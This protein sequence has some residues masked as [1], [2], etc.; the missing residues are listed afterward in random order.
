VKSIFIF[1]SDWRWLIM[2]HSSNFRAPT[3]S[4]SHFIFNIFNSKYLFPAVLCIWFLYFTFATSSQ[5]ISLRGSKQDSKFT[6]DIISTARRKELNQPE[7]LVVVA[8]HAVMRMNKLSI[9]D[10]SDTGWYLLAY[11]KDQGFPGTISSHIRKGIELIKTDDSSVL[12]F[13]GGQTRRDVGPTSEAASYY[14]LAEEKKWMKSLEHRVFLEE[15]ARDSFENLLFSVCRF[16]EITGN[17]PS[18]ISVVGFDFKGNRFQEL[19]RKAIGFPSS[20]FTYVGVRTVH[21]HFDQSKAVRG[22]NVAV[23]SFTKDLYGCNDPSLFQKR[24][25]RNPFRRTV[26]Y[27]L[28]C[29]EMRDLLHWCGPTLFGGIEDLPWGRRLTDSAPS[30]NVVSG[31]A[32]KS[33]II[34]KSPVSGSEVESLNSGQAKVRPVFT[35]VVA[36]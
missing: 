3:A 1:I 4:S 2:R 24:E 20:N 30:G 27:E 36:N 15:Y 21:P 33:K 12:V 34:P 25:T 9:A 29:P 8:G 32:K 23:Q 22:E 7:H 13:S 17:Y 18:R 10:K 31:G 35:E 28:A 26:P 19:H 11:Q 16:R 6:S 14:Y 5:P